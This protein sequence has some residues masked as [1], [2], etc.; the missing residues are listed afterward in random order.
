MQRAQPAK[1]FPRPGPDHTHTT[2]TYG[3]QRHQALE[4]QVNRTTAATAAACRP[5][6]SGFQLDY[7][8]RAPQPPE[9]R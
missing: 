9:R 6:V 1:Q 3:R 4:Y 8:R 5:G 7:V 2:T